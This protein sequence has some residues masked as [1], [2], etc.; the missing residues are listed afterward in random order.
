MQKAGY[1][2]I[3]IFVLPESVWTNYYAVTRRLQKV[4]LEKYKN[5]KTVEEFI[6]SQRYESELYNRF[7]EYYGYVFFIGKK[8]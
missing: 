1:L 2:P 3:A 7:K 6:T 4:F 8:I 5:N